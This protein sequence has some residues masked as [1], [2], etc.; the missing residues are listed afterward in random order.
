PTWDF[1]SDQLVSHTI[2]STMSPGETRSVSITFRNRG[3][4]WTEAK[5][6]RLG[7]V[8]DSDP[9]TTQTRHTISGEVGPNQ[10]YTWTFNLTAPTTPGTYTTDWR[11]VR[12]GVTWFGETC[13]VNVTV[14]SAVQ[15]IIIDNTDAGFSCSANWSTGTMATDKYGSNYRFRATAATS[16]MA[17]WTPNIPVAG[18]WTV[19]AW[20]TA[21]TNRSPNSAYQVYYSGGSVNVYVNQQTNG[22]KW[23]VLTTQNFGTG[24]GYPTKKSCWA[25][26]GYVVIADAVKWHKN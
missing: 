8:G 20:W 22:G 11:M 24:T 16:D 15:D 5:A 19:Y 2:P 13:S 26:T 10:T 23:N 18:S 17:V 12:D 7:A 4:L 3:V 14:Q 25:T 21:G 9:F 6:I 1:Y